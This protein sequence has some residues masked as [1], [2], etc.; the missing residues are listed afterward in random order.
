MSNKNTP[1]LLLGVAGLGL[2][3]AMFFDNTKSA[4]APAL[5]AEP[6]ETEDFSSET[7]KPY[8]EI[9]EVLQVEG[10]EEKKEEDYKKLYEEKIKKEEAPRIIADNRYKGDG[11][12]FD[13]H[14]YF[15]NQAYKRSREL[16]PIDQNI[17]L[18][19]KLASALHEISDSEDEEVV[20]PSI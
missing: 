10:K 11:S 9:I 13:K 16:V 4:R 15:V 19:V 8:T 12:R 20:A 18:A 3:L 17:A 7:D 6:E 14:L 5:Q 2:S 1:I